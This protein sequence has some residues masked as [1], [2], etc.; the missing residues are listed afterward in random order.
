MTGSGSALFALYASKAER[1]FAEKV[2]EGERLMT[3]CRVIP[4]ALVSTS[5][6]RRLWR[7]QLAEYLVDGATPHE[8][9]WPLP[10]RHGQ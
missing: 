1:D 8:L 6:Y 2:L 9:L 4:A 7:R 5:S 3:G 10:N